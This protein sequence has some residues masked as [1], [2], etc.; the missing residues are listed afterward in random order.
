MTTDDK[1]QALSRHYAK[2]DC[3]QAAALDCYFDM[4]EEYV[5]PELVDE[6]NKMYDDVVGG[7]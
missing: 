5:D 4:A 2:L 6:V 7:E 3:E 1:A